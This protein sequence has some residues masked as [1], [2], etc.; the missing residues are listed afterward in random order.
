MNWEIRSFS[1]KA[2]ALTVSMCL[3]RFVSL[4]QRAVNTSRSSSRMSWFLSFN[5]L[6]KPT[7]CCSVFSAACVVGVGA[8]GF[9]L[10]LAGAA[11]GF[12][13]TGVSGL[14]GVGAAEFEFDGVGAAEFAFL[15]GG[16]VDRIA[17]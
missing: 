17:V 10:A 12:G 5:M 7:I 3:P 2:A 11:A 6:P 4:V 14:D 13:V 16:G 8:A 15:G 1:W 9:E